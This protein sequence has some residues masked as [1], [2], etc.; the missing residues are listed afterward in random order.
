MDIAGYEDLRNEQAREARARRADGHRRVVL[1]RGRRRR[2]AQAHGHPRAVDERRRGPAR[3]PVRQGRRVAL[4][5]RPR[6]RAT[7]RRSRRSSPRSSASRRRTSRSAT[8]TPT[9]RPT[10][11]APTAR[12]STPVSGAAV[13]V[14]SRK[15]RDKARAI[16]ATMLETRPEDLAWEKG[17]WY[18]KGDPEQGASINDIARPRL[19]RRR[20]ARGHGGRPR[21]AGHLRPAEPHL[22]VRRLHRGRRHRPR[23]RAR[24]GPPLHRGRRL[25]RA[26]QPDDRRGPDPRR[27]RR[28]HRHRA[29]GGHH[30][31]RARATASTGRSWTT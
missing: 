16:A 10:A 18:V 9:S 3:A 4:R 24:E 19:Q 13:A 31:R 17:R 25:R 14:V 22:P 2:P 8:A 20:D 28:G 12:R 6:A 30:V 5:A 7:R 27:P 21:R 11:S 29:D 26:D 15:V 1:H 23:D